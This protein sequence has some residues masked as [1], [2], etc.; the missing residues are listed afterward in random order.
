MLLSLLLRLIVCSG[1]VVGWDDPRGLT[2]D[3]INTLP[4][5]YSHKG[6]LTCSGTLRRQLHL[7]IQQYLGLVEWSRVVATVRT[8][9][10]WSFRTKIDDFV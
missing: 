4:Q 7:T 2:T 8:T 3:P 5:H 9:A 10:I 1:L 6:S